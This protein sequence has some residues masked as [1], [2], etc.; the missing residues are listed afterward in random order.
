MLSFRTS[1]RPTAGGDRSIHDESRLFDSGVPLGSPGVSGDTE[2]SSSATA[3]VIAVRGSICPRISRLCASAVTAASSRKRQC[4]RSP[5]G[6][7]ELLGFRE[8]RSVSPAGR[9]GC[10]S[11]HLAH[12]GRREGRLHASESA[13]DRRV[14]PVALGTRPEGQRGRRPRRLPLMQAKQRRA[15]LPLA[16][17]GN[18]AERSRT[19][20]WVVTQHSATR[21]RVSGLCLRGARGGSVTFL[22]GRRVAR[23]P[24]QTMNK[25][26]APM[27]SGTR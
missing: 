23:C 8:C 5:L 13:E 16:N 18:T 21:A 17:A 22:I 25:P 24:C 3:L 10:S 1:V 7:P 4:R 27:A 9:R 26:H 15:V 20:A 14:G 6:F 2:L 12:R 11:S 19:S